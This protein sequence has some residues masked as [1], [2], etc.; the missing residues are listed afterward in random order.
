[1]RV[2]VLIERWMPL[3]SLMLKWM[4]LVRLMVKCRQTNMARIT[5]SGGVG[6]DSAFGFVFV[7]VKG[8]CRELK[9]F[10][11]FESNLGSYCAENSLNFFEFLKHFSHRGQISYFVGAA[12][13]VIL[14]LKAF[15]V[16]VLHLFTN[17][18]HNKT[19]FL[20]SR[21]CHP[22]T[23]KSVF[24]SKKGHGIILIYQFL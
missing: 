24:C 18:P 12:Q 13:H 3:A 16:K 19:A 14:H 21:L 10:N 6:K 7:F 23:K 4:P 2:Q 17:V 11:I 20:L 8:R 15:T 22:L 9:M 1:M 5:Q